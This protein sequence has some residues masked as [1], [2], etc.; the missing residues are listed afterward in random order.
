MRCG[1]DAAH[2]RERGLLGASD[3]EVLEFAFLQDRILVTANVKDF[4]H[5]ARSVSLHPGIVLVLEGCLSRD[6]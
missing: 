2:V 1:F 6:E 3:R 5:L 4:Q